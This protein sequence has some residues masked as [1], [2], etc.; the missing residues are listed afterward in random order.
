MYDISKAKF[1]LSSFL[2]ALTL[3][4]ID[5]VLDQKTKTMYLN[6]PSKSYEYELPMSVIKSSNDYAKVIKE[7]MREFGFI[8]ET[9]KV[10]YKDKDIYWT[11]HLGEANYNSKYSLIMRLTEEI[12]SK[13]NKTRK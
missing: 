5:M 3:S 2:G 4:G 12:F 10:R 7:K 6:I 13:Q 1:L 8:D 11:K 9:W